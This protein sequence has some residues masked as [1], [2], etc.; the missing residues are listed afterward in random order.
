MSRQLPPIDMHAHVD[1]RISARDLE[2]L[3]AVVFAATRSLAEFEQT[4]HRR[5]QVTIW[6]LGCHPG[7]RTA[8]AEFDAEHFAGLM[9]NTP[10][11]SEVGL[12]GAARTDTETQVRIFRSILALAAQVP[13]IVSVHSK[14]AT[15]HVLDLVEESGAPGIVLHWWLG[16]QSETQRAVGLGCLFSVNRSMDYERLRRAGVPLDRLLPETDHPAGNRAGGGLLTQPGWTLDVERAVADAYALT[17]EEV[18]AQFW[19]TLAGLTRS[20]DLD[21]L[22][23]MPVRAMLEAARH[24]ATVPPEGHA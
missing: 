5:D 6:G 23:P 24:Q 8:Q 12:D 19:S 4:L 15:S 10:L 3:G 22:F 18:R 7:V 11:L 1:T 13:R 14:R 9:R 2:G 20:L 16:S 21:A 17:P